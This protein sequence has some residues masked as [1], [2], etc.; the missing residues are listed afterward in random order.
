M[1]GIPTADRG[2]YTLDEACE[3][4]GGISRPLIYGYI[5]SRRLRSVK[6]GARRMIPADALSSFVSSLEA[7]AS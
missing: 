5:N 2:L 3:W 7:E 1:S 4:L 6:M